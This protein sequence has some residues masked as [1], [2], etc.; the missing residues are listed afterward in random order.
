MIKPP[1]RLY[2]RNFTAAFD[3][4]RRAETADE[5]VHR[6]EHGFEENVEQQ[7][8]Q[9]D[10]RNQHHGLDRQGQGDVGVRAAAS[11]RRRRSSPRS[12]ASAPRSW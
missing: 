9:R 12:A 1:K 10:Q 8:V 11:A 5:E 4:P 6:D 7:N 3:R 2:I